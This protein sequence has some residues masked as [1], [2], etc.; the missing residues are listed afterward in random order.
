M[1]GQPV[2]HDDA[3]PCGKIGDEV[4]S[5][6]KTWTGEIHHDAKPCKNSWGSEVEA[7]ALQLT[8]KALVL[9]IYRN[10]AQI[11]WL[12]KSIRCQEL[13]FPLLGIGMID[14]K[15]VQA[16]VRVTVRKRVKASAEEDILPDVSAG[17]LLAVLLG[18][19]LRRSEPAVCVAGTRG[20]LGLKE[21]F[22]L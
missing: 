3:A 10:I 5:G 8:G 14:L 2:I 16:G 19:G 18:C 12:W 22:Q 7:A 13:A 17:S 4:E 11:P 20:A 21:L 1:T 9:E 6:T 15:Y